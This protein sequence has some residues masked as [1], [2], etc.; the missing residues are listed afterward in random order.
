MFCFIMVCSMRH[1]VFFLVGFSHSCGPV[2]YQ[3]QYNYFWSSRLLYLSW[4]AE[5][6]SKAGG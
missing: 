4:C 3:Y 2:V 6:V 1:L 5:C